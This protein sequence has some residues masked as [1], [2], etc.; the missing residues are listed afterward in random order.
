MHSTTSNVNF[1]PSLNSVERQLANERWNYCSQTRCFFHEQHDGGYCTLGQCKRWC[2]SI[3]DALASEDIYDF[4]LGVNHLPPTSA[5]A[6]RVLDSSEATPFSASVAAAMGRR[7]ENDD[8]HFGARY[9]DDDG[10]KCRTDQ[11]PEYR[12]GKNAIVHTERGEAF[13]P[14][15]AAKMG[16]ISDVNNWPTLNQVRTCIHHSTMTMILREPLIF[17]KSCD[18]RVF[19]DNDL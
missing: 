17:S 3:F 5:P 10:N 8:D 12:D 6:F 2:Y 16:H 14:D 11:R 19:C 9:D 4:Q 15:G 7:G 18:L 1:A 13:S